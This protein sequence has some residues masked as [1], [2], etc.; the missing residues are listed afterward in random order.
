MRKFWDLV[1]ES[2]IGQIA[3]ALMFGGVTVYLLVTGKPVPGE[4][5]ATNTAMIGFYFGSKVAASN[6]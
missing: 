1:R 6:K 2:V 4:L 3:L 5:W